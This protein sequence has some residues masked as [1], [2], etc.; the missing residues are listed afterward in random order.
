MARLLGLGS[1]HVDRLGVAVVRGAL[2]SEDEKDEGCR[3]IVADSPLQH[4]LALDLAEL[5]QESLVVDLMIPSEVLIALIYWA[6][7]IDGQ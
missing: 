6:C 4:A 2:L 7:Q 5:L 3:P 1:F